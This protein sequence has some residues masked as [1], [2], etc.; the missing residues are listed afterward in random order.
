[1]FDIIINFLIEI[2]NIGVTI[3]GLIVLSFINV[4]IVLTGF[5]VVFLIYKK[6]FFPAH[7]KVEPMHYT[8]AK[9]LIL[10]FITRAISDI[11]KAANDKLEKKAED[12]KKEDKT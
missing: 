6:V 7:R 1:M 11:S 9:T 5:M 2:G 12:K 10:P 4:F 3:F 8:L